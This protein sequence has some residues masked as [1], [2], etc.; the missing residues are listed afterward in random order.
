LQHKT[1]LF[2][3]LLFTVFFVAN[4]QNGFHFREKSQLKQRVSFKLINN[5][6]VIPVTINGQEL[7]FILDTGVDKTVIFNLSKND[8]IGLLNTEKITLRGL[9]GGE[10]VTAILSKNNKMEVKGLF[11]YNESIYIILKDFFDLSSKMGT[12]IHGIIGYNLIK[13]FVVKINYKA[14]QIDFYNPDTY[15]YKKCKKCEILPIEFYRKKPFVNVAVQLDTLGTKLIPVKMLVDSGGSDAIWLFENFN[16]EIKTPK[17]FFNAILG[18][19]LSGTIFGKRSRIPKLKIGKFEIK[20]PTVSFLDSLSTLNAQKF[21]NRNG[22]IGGNILK[23]FTVW[24]DYPGKQ[25]M[26]KKNS[27]FKA[28]FNYNMS[29]L[30]IVYGGKELVKE[31]FSKPSTF[32]YGEQTGG[33]NTISF[34]TDFKY[35]FMSTYEIRGVVKNSVSGKAGLKVGD[36]VLAIN[37]KLVYN[38]SLND[39]ISKLQ[40]KENKKI[41][42]TVKRNGLKMTFI[43]RLEKRI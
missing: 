6:I 24:L 3:A 32:S 41:R 43:F 37:R 1:F 27:S 17:R 16:A 33:D 14:K 19:G 13:N 2:L 11:A 38:Y 25:I 23:R 42:I 12:T 40:E 9:G 34:I 39:I 22:S 31:E 26:L 29:G 18:E 21:K 30:D 36:V 28:A 7:S 4:A 15:A 5:L 8:S 35:K 10:P 20:K